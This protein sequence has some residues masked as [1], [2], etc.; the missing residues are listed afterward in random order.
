MVEFD[1]KELS[2][3]NFRDK[4]IGPTDPKDA[5]KDSLRG[6]ALA[7]WKGFG[8]R[9][10]PNVG[11]NCCHVSAS[12]FESL[13]E[14]MNWLNVKAGEDPWG[15][16]LL[17]A[18]VRPKT[19]KDGSSDPVVIYGS[20]VEPTSTPDVQV[21]RVHSHG[22]LRDFGIGADELAKINSEAKESIIW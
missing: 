6:A 15:E 10:E 11:E 2:W 1:P 18:G 9:S 12:P 16:A 19:I 8:L 3:A 13:C 7:N 5:P 4:V 17:A 20:E 21:G 14:K 22:R